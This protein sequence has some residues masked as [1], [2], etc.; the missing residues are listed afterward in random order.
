MSD[1]LSVNINATLTNGN[2]N[3]AF[4]PGA[5]TFDQTATG[6]I[7]QIVVVN[8]SASEVISFGSVTTEGWCFLRNLDAT[9]YVQYGPDSG[10]SLIVFGRIE[11]GEVA[12]FR[13]DPTTTF[14][15]QANTAAVKLQVALLED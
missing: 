13:L 5:L 11:A 4:A 12:A 2:Q 6:G 7:D 3:F 14:R 10:S 1:E 9:N 8:S 15:A